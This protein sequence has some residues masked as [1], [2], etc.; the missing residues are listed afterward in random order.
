MIDK[1][2]AS[3]ASIPVP[4]TLA[5]RVREVLDINDQI[6]DGVIRIYKAIYGGFDKN[7]ETAV[8]PSNFSEALD[9]YISDIDGTRRLICELIDRMGI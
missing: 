2:L 3:T 8:D 1:T 7:E 5:V 4:E 6:H 9:L